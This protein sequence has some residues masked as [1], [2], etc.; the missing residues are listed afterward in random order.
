M[1]P[2]DIDRRTHG[3]KDGEGGGHMKTFVNHAHGPAASRRTGPLRRSAPDEPWP[4]RS[5][6]TRGADRGGVTRLRA[7]G[8]PP[9]PARNR[10]DG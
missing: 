4:P 6:R 8:N 9:R 7:E 1:L 5:P 2:D 10:V 3:R